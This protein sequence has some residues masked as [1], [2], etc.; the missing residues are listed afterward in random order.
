M[1][2][3]SRRGLSAILWAIVWA[4][5]L[6]ASSSHAEPNALR[7]VDV[8]RDGDRIVLRAQLSHSL[9]TLPASFSTLTPPRIVID[10]PETVNATSTMR[11]RVPACTISR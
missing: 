11:V 9:K 5:L 10:F 1:S 4:M 8:S 7:A 3:R 2:Q 6:L